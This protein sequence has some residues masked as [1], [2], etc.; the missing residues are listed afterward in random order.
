MAT[1]RYRVKQIFYTL[2][3]EGWFTGTPAVFVRFVGCNMWSGQEQD[4]QRDSERLGGE[5]GRPT[6]AMFCDTDFTSEGSAAYTAAELVS[7]VLRVGQGCRF[8]VC[9]GGE[10]LLQ[11]DGELM[12][13]MH[14]KSGGGGRLFV[15]VETNGTVS[16]RRFRSSNKDEST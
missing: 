6:C 12:E 10:P 9:T 5:D 8:V 4:R 7:E 3:G 13:A 1:K 2:Q 14:G 16:L 11:M 15:S